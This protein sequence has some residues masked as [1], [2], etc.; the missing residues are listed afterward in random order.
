MPFQ[1]D[2]E[3]IIAH[4]WSK[5]EES[6]TW[7]T[8]CTRNHTGRSCWDRRSSTW[9][10]WSRSRR[11]QKPRSQVWGR[12]K[13]PPARPRRCCRRCT[14]SCCSRWGRT[15]GKIHSGVAPGQFG[16]LRSW[17]REKRRRS[18]MR[19]SL[20]LSLSQPLSAEI[21][22]SSLEKCCGAADNKCRCA[23]LNTQPGRAEGVFH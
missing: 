17:T 13:R 14:H 18:R 10:R 22:L 21:N 16:V 7:A 8:T 5:N 20:P 1:L 12:R 2:I 3:R 11:R 23:Y 6:R 19:R 4:I 9:R 15:R